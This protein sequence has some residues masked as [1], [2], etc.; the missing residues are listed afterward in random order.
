MSI[1]RRRPVRPTIWRRTPGRWQSCC[2]PSAP[3]A[4]GKSRDRPT[5]PTLVWSPNQEEH[6]RAAWHGDAIWASDVPGLHAGP[7]THARPAAT[8]AVAQRGQ[9]SQKWVVC[10]FSLGRDADIAVCDLERM[11]GPEAVI[12]VADCARVI[13]KALREGNHHALLLQARLRVHA[14]AAKPGMSPAAALHADLEVQLAVPTTVYQ[15]LQA[16]D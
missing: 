12:R 3:Q 15:G 10:M 2:T 4:S 6:L 1:C 7:I 5:P 11:L 16:F 14:R 9:Q 8:L 13:L